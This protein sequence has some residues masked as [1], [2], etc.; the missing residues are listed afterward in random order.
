MS[1]DADLEAQAPAVNPWLAGNFAPVDDELTTGPLPVT[2]EI[3]SGLRGEYLRNGFNPAVTP[4]PSYHWF[5]GDGMIHGLSL[6]DGAASYRNRWVQTRA[7]RA[8][9]REGRSLFGGMSEFVLPDAELLA[10]VGMGKNPANTNIVRHGDRLLALWEAGAPT[11]LDADLVT[12]GEYDFGGRLQGPM[13]AH[14]K[15]DPATGAMCFF[16]A[17]PFAPFLRYHEA[18]T[19]GALVRTEAIDLPAAVM[20]HDFVVTAGHAVFFDLPA[21]LDV[22]G[23]LGGGPLLSWQPERGARIGVMPRS[24]TGADVMWFELEPVYAFHCLNG[25]DEGD[26]VVVDGC[27]ADGLVI[28]FGDDPPADPGFPSLHRWRLDLATGQVTTEQLD[29]RATDFPRIN[30]AHTG[31]PNRY[32]YVGHTGSFGPTGARFDGVV[33][34][35]FATGT[36]TVHRY[37]PTQLSGE[38]VFAPDPDGTAED[39]GWLLNFV[40]DVSTDRTDFVILDAR[41]LAADPVAR[42]HLPRRVPFGPHGN[43]LPA[44]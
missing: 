15:I 6:A 24:G 1:V 11:E 36:S 32:G 2:G 18:D 41:D 16:G 10:E 44:S 8:E 23:M 40:Y 12:V 26:T 43:W 13:T 27:R 20:M 22:E 30:D 35:D 38:A 25:W 29:D 33:K 31:L 4:R 17:S 21:I 42:V 7:L 28:G 5:D 39:D 34:H 9:L 37:G 3:P 14:P 19:T